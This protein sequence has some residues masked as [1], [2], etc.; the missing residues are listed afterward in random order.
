MMLH[1]AEYQRAKAAI[2]QPID[3]FSMMIEERTHAGVRQAEEIASISDNL[4]TP[5]KVDEEFKQLAA[6]EPIPRG[7]GD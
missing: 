7:T 5:A 4:L 6:R 3:E 2:M 1:D